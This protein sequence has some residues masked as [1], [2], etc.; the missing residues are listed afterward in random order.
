MTEVTVGLAGGVAHVRRHFRES[1]AR[2]MIYTA[3]RF[4]GEDLYRMNVASACTTPEALLET[5]RG[6]ARD[7]A[8]A[9][10][11]AVR[12]AK[13]SFQTTENLSIYEGYRFEQ[14]QTKELSTSK[15]TS[16]AMLAFKEKRAPNFDS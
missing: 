4:Y 13:R 16:E 7:I 3:R 6:I 1:D 8:K 14:G 2:L 11:S 10:P 5:A 9:S 12:A 15:D